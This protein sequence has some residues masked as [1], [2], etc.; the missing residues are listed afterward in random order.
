MRPPAT[1]RADLRRESRAAMSRT[2][3]AF[4]VGVVLLL[5]LVAF[6]CGG[7]EEAGS[8]TAADECT[9][10]SATTATGGDDLAAIEVTVKG[11]L[12]EGGC[13]RMT[14]KFLEDQTFQDDP[15]EACETFE[16]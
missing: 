8:T 7:D 15:E 9:A 3:R 16:S 6:G 11:W 2:T 4:T 1:F 12:R 14:D 13:E 10:T 5:A